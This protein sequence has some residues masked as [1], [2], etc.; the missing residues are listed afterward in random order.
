VPPPPTRRSPIHLRISTNASGCFAAAFLGGL[1]VVSWNLINTSREVA[2]DG[3]PQLVVFSVRNLKAQG[4]P[5]NDT[6]VVIPFDT[7]LQGPHLNI[8]KDGAKER[9]V[10]NVHCVHQSPVPPGS[11]IEPVWRTDAYE[12]AVA[13]RFAQESAQ[14]DA[15]SA[16]HERT[17]LQI[18]TAI[19]GPVGKQLHVGATDPI[20]VQETATLAGSPPSQRVHEAAMQSVQDMRALYD[21]VVGQV[22]GGGQPVSSS[23][24]FF[25][26]SNYSNNGIPVVTAGQG[27]F[28]AQ[29]GMVM[30]AY[31]GQA[32]AQPW[33]EV[34]YS[35]GLAAAEYNSTLDEVALFFV[36]GSLFRP[37]TPWFSIISDLFATPALAGVAGLSCRWPH[38]IPKWSRQWPR[39]RFDA[40]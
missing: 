22:L 35:V 29:L 16:L 40:Y 5:V 7:M 13:D 19:E 4:I 12:L 31:R 24:N 10:F 38:A 18:Q 25:H 30:Q 20:I 17:V 15:R 1:R 2:A 28:T 33:S 9:G 34:L 27:F 26:L 11:I 37:L 21:G 14:I 8:V 6:H 39:I 23:V 36:A 3:F 32:R